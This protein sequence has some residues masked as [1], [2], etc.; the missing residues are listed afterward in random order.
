M[1]TPEE[2]RNLEPYLEMLKSMSFR[3]GRR[4]LEIVALDNTNSVQSISALGLRIKL[5]GWNGAI[6][7][8]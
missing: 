1:Q 3:L 8:H 5:A 7:P 2:M 6:E 4:V